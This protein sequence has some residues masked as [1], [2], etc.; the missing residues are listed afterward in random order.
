VSEKEPYIDFYTGDWKK[1]QAVARC[2]PATRGVWFD[3]LCGMHDDSRSGKLCGTADELARIARCSAAE[4][5]LAL[6]ELR[7][8]GAADVTERNGTY[9]VVNRRMF[10]KAQEREA[11]RL[12]QSR[13]RSQSGRNGSVA[14][15]VTRPPSISLPTSNKPPPP[16]ETSGVDSKTRQ[17]LEEEVFECGVE[18]A[19]RAVRTALEA[20]CSPAEIRAV[21][22]A[23]CKRNGDLGAGYL[24]YRLMELRPGQE[25]DRGWP[26]QPPEVAEKKAVQSRAK[27]EQTIEQDY[28]KSAAESDVAAAEREKKYG[29]ELDAMDPAEVAEIC[30]PHSQ[31]AALL[32][33]K[34]KSP[35][36]RAWL[37]VQLE[38]RAAK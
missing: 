1:D 12:R 21:V 8:T 5:V 36:L 38:L 15:E 3:L 22:L 32:R 37:L 26:K 29:A 30:R 11:N 33:K 16:L 34:Q 31:M 17:A 35:L 10:R 27:R 18:D 14:R 28:Q 19:R 9:T 25:P 23:W 6:N 2:S 13:Y 7:T 4:L 24:H 20:G